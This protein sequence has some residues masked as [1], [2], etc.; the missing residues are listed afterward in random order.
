MSFGPAFLH[1]LLPFEFVALGIDKHM[2]VA[3]KTGDTVASY[4]T[5]V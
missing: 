4:F 1:P 3:E 2:I 5:Q